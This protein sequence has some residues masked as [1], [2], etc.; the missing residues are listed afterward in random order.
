MSCYCTS[1]CTIRSTKTKIFQVEKAL[2]PA[3]PLSLSSFHRWQSPLFNLFKG[4][5]E[6]VRLSAVYGRA[7]ITAD[8]RTRSKPDNSD[9]MGGCWVGIWL[10]CQ[11]HTPA[12]RA[13][14]KYRKKSVIW[15]TL[16]NNFFFSFLWTWNPHGG[17][18][19]ADDNLGWATI[20]C[21]NL[22]RFTPPSSLRSD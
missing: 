8:N 22:K 5:T 15:R 12:A 20:I 14:P 10:L 9:E 19:P 11:C 7:I 16:S 6:D 13:W 2:V 4:I 17:H 18:P 3:G 21:S 1:M